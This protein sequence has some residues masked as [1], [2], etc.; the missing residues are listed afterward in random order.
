MRAA[1]AVAAPAKRQLA[2]VGAIAAM[3]FTA[4]STLTMWVFSAAALANNQSEESLRQV[5]L[6]VASFS[7]LS[8]AGIGVGIWLLRRKRPGRS[9]LASL[10]PAA[11]MA[12]TLLYLLGC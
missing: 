7:L 11:V 10:L 1:T 6:W 3:I 4:G 12:A 8:M 5:E 9:A 2:V